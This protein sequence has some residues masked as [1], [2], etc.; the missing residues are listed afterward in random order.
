MLGFWT[1]SIF[2]VGWLLDCG[3]AYPDTGTGTSEDVFYLLAIKEPTSSEGMP[4]IEP[5][6]FDP[7]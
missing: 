2:L 5:G 1:H 7:Q 3:R 6:S 4:G